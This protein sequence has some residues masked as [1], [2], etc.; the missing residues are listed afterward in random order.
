MRKD[1]PGLALLEVA[2]AGL[3]LAVLAWIG[4][5]LLYAIWPGV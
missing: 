1:N 5:V 2:A 4:I 3:G